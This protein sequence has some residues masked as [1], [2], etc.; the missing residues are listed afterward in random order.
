M[1]IGLVWPTL[2][3]TQLLF[4]AD[5]DIVFLTCWA[6]E[7]TNM[8]SSTKNITNT[9]SSMYAVD[10]RLCFTDPVQTLTRPYDVGIIEQAG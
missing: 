10:A 8:L 9:E 3:L 4:L 6:D 2:N 7:M 5:R 1:V